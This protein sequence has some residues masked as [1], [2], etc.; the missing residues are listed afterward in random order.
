[1]CKWRRH[2]MSVIR[3]YMGEWQPMQSAGEE[4]ERLLA[5]VISCNEGVQH[6][7][8]TRSTW[9]ALYSIEV[10]EHAHS[11]RTTHEAD[12][13]YGR[14]MIVIVSSNKAWKA[15]YFDIQVS[16][17]VCS[18][19]TPYVGWAMICMSSLSI[20]LDGMS[21]KINTW[22]GQASLSMLE[23]CGM[24]HAKMWIEPP[25]MMMRLWQS[26]GSERTSLP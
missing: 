5:V 19:C 18:A 26:L 17:C 8:M 4:L 3:F 7:T 6:I 9:C 23:S 16:M 13:F 24:L 10:V 1:M 25:S 12:Y 21:L 11:T 20:A 22:Y 2:I 14:W 15:P